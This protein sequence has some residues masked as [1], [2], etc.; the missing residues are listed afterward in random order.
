MKS[1]YSTYG[2]Q[3]KRYLD[4]EGIDLKSRRRDILYRRYYLM[5]FLREKTDLSLPAIGFIFG[6]GHASIINALKMVKDLE[7]YDDYKEYTALEA[8]HFPMD[9]PQEEKDSTFFAYSKIPE[10]LINLQNNFLET[11]G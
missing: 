7:I 9:A 1:E 2:Q 8:E 5:N 4:V 11:Y 3:V 10:S 6:K